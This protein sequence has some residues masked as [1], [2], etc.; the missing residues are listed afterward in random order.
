MGLFVIIYGATA[1]EFDGDKNSRIYMAIGGIVIIVVVLIY[2]YLKNWW[3]D[4]V[5]KRKTLQKINAVLFEMGMIDDL[6]RGFR[7]PI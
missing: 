1:S 7:G 5:E 6:A 2:F 4:S 3:L